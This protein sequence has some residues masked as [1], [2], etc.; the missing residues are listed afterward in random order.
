MKYAIRITKDRLDLIQVLNGGVRP[1]IK[2]EEN[3][4]ED[5]YLLL[6]AIPPSTTKNHKIKKEDDLYNN[7]GYLHDVNLELI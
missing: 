7:E 4:S 6:T 1:E 5:R 3:T 2:W